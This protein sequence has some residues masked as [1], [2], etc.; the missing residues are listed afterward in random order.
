MNL[1]T[2]VSEPTTCSSQ[3]INVS[4]GGIPPDTPFDC[5]SKNPCN[6][7]NTPGVDY[8]RTTFPTFIIRCG[9]DNSCNYIACPVGHIF[10]FSATKCVKP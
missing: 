2:G 8:Y 1:L 7:R 9:A 10:D 3:A 5:Q 4:G 6:P